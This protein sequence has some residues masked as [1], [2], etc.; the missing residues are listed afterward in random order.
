MNRALVRLRGVPD[1]EADGIRE[2]LREASIA[3]YETP[4]S[5]WLISAGA[6]WL[7]DPAD[8]PRAETV[9]EQFQQAWC[10]QARRAAPP[11][12]FREQLRQR[13]LEMLGIA[14][15]VAFMLWLMAWP[16]LHLVGHASR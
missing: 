3:F 13:P 2:A 8:R 1:E 9:L 6:I 4:P 15:A 12:S 10:A 14:I 11:P 16:V 5:R 7:M